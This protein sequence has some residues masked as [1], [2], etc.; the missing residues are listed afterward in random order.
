[1]E[2]SSSRLKPPRTQAVV[3]AVLVAPGEALLPLV[4]QQQQLPGPLDATGEA[5]MTRSGRVC[6][7]PLEYWRGERLLRD[8]RDEAPVA[9]AAPLLMT[10]VTA[11]FSPPAKSSSI[12]AP[13]VRSSSC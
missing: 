5:F 12:R 3:A 2:P 13:K 9:I 6:V 8:P 10:I 1:M 4:A 7:K 11:P